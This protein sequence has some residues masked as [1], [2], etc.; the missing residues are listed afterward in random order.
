MHNKAGSTVVLPSGFISFTI[1]G[2]QGSD[3][4]RWSFLDGQQD[5]QRVRTCLGMLLTSYPP[6]GGTVYKKWKE[7]LDEAAEAAEAA[8][9]AHG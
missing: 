3:G 8:A 6:L 5:L 7:L 9:A 1:S 4:M 2:S